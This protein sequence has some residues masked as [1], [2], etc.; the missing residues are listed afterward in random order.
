MNKKGIYITSTGV[1][2]RIAIMESGKLAQLLVERIDKIKVVGDI[3]KGIVTQVSPGLNAAFVNIGLEKSAFLPLSEVKDKHVDFGDQ[4]VENHLKL[5]QGQEIFIQITKSPLG[6]K[7]PRATTYISIPG[8]Y[9]VFMPGRKI[10]G[11]SRKIK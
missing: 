8:R 3:Y 11:I 7:G 4:V 9:I 6:K 10:V 1:E 5:E 2:L